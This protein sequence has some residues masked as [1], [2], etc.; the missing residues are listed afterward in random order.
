MEDEFTIFA[1]V[2]IKLTGDFERVLSFHKMGRIGLASASAH[3]HAYNFY[4]V[5]SD[6]F[7]HMLKDP[8][9]FF[10]DDCDKTLIKEMTQSTARSF[11]QSLDA[12]SLIFAHSILDAA[13]FDCLRISALAAP[14]EWMQ[15]LGKRT[16][17]LNELGEKTRAEHLRE[18]IKRE[19]NQFERESLL[20]KVDRLFQLCKPKKSIFLTNGFQFDRDRLKELDNLRHAIVH[21]PEYEKQFSKLLEDLDFLRKSGLHIA[22]MIA[23]TYNTGINGQEVVDAYKRRNAGAEF[24]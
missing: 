5:M 21:A 11:K 9:A 3:V 2:W 7:K 16:V 23:E 13:L 18:A 20:K 15:F 4:M 10:R 12:A 24:R 1:D 6:D 19:L 14:E 17:A 8:K 22:S